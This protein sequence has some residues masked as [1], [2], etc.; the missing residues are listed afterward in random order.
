MLN[1]LH[2]LGDLVIDILRQFSA[3]RV[4]IDI[5]LFRPKVLPVEILM[6]NTVLAKSDLGAIV[7]LSPPLQREAKG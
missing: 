7:K 3:R 1:L 4:V 6:L 5:V 2:H